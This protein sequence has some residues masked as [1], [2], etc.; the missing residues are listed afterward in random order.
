MR[1]CLYSSRSLSVPSN[2][3]VASTSSAPPGGATFE[4]AVRETVSLIRGDAIDWARGAITVGASGTNRLSSPS[5]TAGS[6]DG[7]L[8]AEVRREREGP[9]RRSPLGKSSAEGHRLDH[10]TRERNE[11]ADQRQQGAVGRCHSPSSGR[12]GPVWRSSSVAGLTPSS[13]IEVSESS[14]TPVD[15]DSTVSEPTPLNSSQTLRTRSCRSGL[16]SSSWYTEAEV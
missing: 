15:G 13:A 16:P 9:R 2:R 12:V 5:S 4:L 7:V 1:R 6:A 14:W 10:V 3:R 8:G 11:H